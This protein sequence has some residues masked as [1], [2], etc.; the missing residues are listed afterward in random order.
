LNTAGAKRRDLKLLAV[1]TGLMSLG[2]MG[3]RPLVAI[4]AVALDIG[5]EEIGVLVAVFSLL[6]LVLAFVVGSWMD[7]H[8]GSGRVIF[9]GALGCAVGLVL[10]YLLAGRLGLYL[11]QLITGS[12]FTVYMLAMQNYSGREATDIWARE[13]AVLL[14]STG[15]S[16]G[17]LAGPL[18]T[19]VFADSFGHAT[20]FLLMAVP[21]FAVLGFVAPLIA[22]DRAFKPGAASRVSAIPNPVRVLGYNPYMGRAFLVSILVLMGKDLYLAYFP[23]LAISAGMSASLIGLIISLHNGGAVV[24][25]F[26]M[27][28]LVRLLGKNRVIVLSVVLSGVLFLLLPLSGDPLVMAAISIG[29]GLGLGVG[30]PLA[31]TRTM[32]LSPPDKIGEVL[33]VRIAANRLTQ[34][35]TPLMIGGVVAFTGLPGV[36]VAVGAT[37]MIGGL[38]LSVPS[39]AETQ[40]FRDRGEAEGQGGKPPPRG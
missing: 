10:P 39:H 24:V 32:N 14:T 8:G 38:R 12:G 11:S 25:R 17:S 9:I 30:Q 34:V 23:V 19:G 27:L 15:L 1:G 37:L 35:V 29:I 26:T 6:P 2:V 20:A 4:Y 21:G 16:V 5:P 7:T 18:V 28:P 3:T 22:G 31:T 40:S 36:F 13:R 33:G